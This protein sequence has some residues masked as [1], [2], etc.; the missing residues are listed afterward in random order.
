MKYVIVG[1]NIA[2]VTAATELRKLDPESQVTIYTKESYPYYY[3]PKLWSI[4]AGEAEPED[5][6]FHTAEWYAEQGIDLQL[7]TNVVKLDAEAKTITLESGGVVAYDKLLIAAGSHCFIPPVEG[8][9]LPNVFS[10]RN[11]DDTKAIIESADHSKEAV[12]IGGGLLGL[13]TAKALTDR[14]L[15]VSVI[16]FFP[17]LLPRQLD[18]EGGAVLS[19]HLEGFGMTLLTDEVTET[20][21]KNERGLHVSLKSGKQLD[22]DMVIFSTGIRSNCGIW[23]DAGV[24][25]NR[26][27]LVNEY[28]E[29]NL[30]DVYAAGD[31]A[32]FNGLVYGLVAVAR[33]QAQAAAANMVAPKSKA[34][35]GTMPS[36]RLKIAGLAFNALGESTLEGDG[37]TVLRVSEPENG[38]Y[39]RLA[40]KDGKVLGAIVFGDNRRSMAFKN[41]ITNGTDVSGKEDQLLDVGF[42]LKSL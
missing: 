26:G 15:H 8:A 41:L 10:L 29:T 4:I 31:V 25:D 1:G 32:E 33:E 42:N 16:E 5:T 19:A 23:K 36:T 40:I 13:E 9:D 18:P 39:E 35:T 20:I 27:L 3:R 6:Y 38:R 17:S 22:A 30:P 37:V 12:L 28:M 7:N 34:Y 21:S 24:E 11:M 14:G 2:G